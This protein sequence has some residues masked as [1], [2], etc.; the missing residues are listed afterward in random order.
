MP[1]LSGTFRTVF[2]GCLYGTVKFNSFTND[3]SIFSDA[4][5]FMEHHLNTTEYIAQIHFQHVT[6]MSTNNLKT[7]HSLHHILL[8]MSKFD[9]VRQCQLC[10]KLTPEVHGFNLLKP[11]ILKNGLREGNFHPPTPRKY[12]WARRTVLLHQHIW[13]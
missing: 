10:V 11:Y 6:F 4:L 12:D 9:S 13:Y 7:H 3:F 8:W 2:S 1:S 5:N